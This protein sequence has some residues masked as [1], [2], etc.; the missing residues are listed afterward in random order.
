MAVP[1]P[2]LGFRIE[3]RDFSLS[4]KVYPDAIEF[5]QSNDRTVGMDRQEIIARIF[6]QLYTIVQLL[7]SD[8]QIR[9]IGA[10]NGL[11]NGFGR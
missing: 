7:R 9:K 8:F 5:Q 1:G 2:L 6:V 11:L 3:Q 10:N 4:V